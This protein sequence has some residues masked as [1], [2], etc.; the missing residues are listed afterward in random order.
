MGT[1]RS[2]RRFLLDQFS[3]M[4]AIMTDQGIDDQSAAP[5]GAAMRA[6]LPTQ[7]KEQPDPFLQMSTEVPIGPSGLT[8]FGIAVVVIL[9]VVFYGLN[10][11][12]RANETASASPPAATGNSGGPAPAAP[13][14]TDKAG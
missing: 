2:L 1:S 6:E 11:P 12:D 10:G 13:Q 8:L 9:G 14:P 4:R 5:H 7:E 3:L